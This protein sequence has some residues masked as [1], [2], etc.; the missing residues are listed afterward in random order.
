MDEIIG[1]PRGTE[2]GLPP[3]V[4]KPCNDCPWRRASA[5]GW[6][7]PMSP[8]EWLLTAH[9]DHPIACHLTIKGDEAWGG[10]SVRQ[11]A[12]AAIYRQNVAKSPRIA[13]DAAH[14]FEPDVESVFASDREFRDHHGPSYA[15]VYAPYKNGGVG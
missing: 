4:A 10:P 12:G 2:L 8:E 11:C 14:A 3:P 5:A 6:L 9:S 13:D 7:G 1:V 15:R